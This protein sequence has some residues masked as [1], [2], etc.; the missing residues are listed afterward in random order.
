[1]NPLEKAWLLLKEISDEERRA[2]ARGE[3]PPRL[4]GGGRGPVDT[5]PRGQP[6]LR[7][8][9]AGGELPLLDDDERALEGEGRMYEGD[10][11]SGTLQDVWGRQFGAMGGDPQFDPRS[12]GEQDSFGGPVSP[13]QEE[14]VGDL[15]GGKTLPELMAGDPEAQRGVGSMG[16]LAR[17]IDRE[18]EREAEREAGKEKSRTETRVI[19]I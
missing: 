14:D 9:R 18:A 17:N 8:L 5:G 4:G 2:A 16:R 3:V 7:E 1:M 19:R 10:P 12:G 6:S 15:Y 11:P 13:D